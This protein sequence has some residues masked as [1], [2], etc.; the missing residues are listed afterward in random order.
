MQALYQWQLTGQ[1]TRE[2]YQQFVEDQEVERADLEYFK[3]LLDEIAQQHAS[4]DQALAP[5]TERG[6]DVVD[7]VE[8]AVLRI[9]AYELM[10]RLD[11]PYR[12]VVN[13]AIELSKK[14]GAEGSH[15][16]VNGVLDKL[17]RETRGVE[18]SMSQKT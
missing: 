7:P 12:V 4:L 5:F 18:L 8:K 14:F 13:E 15:K 11:V 10:H 1:P 9:G 2:I 6:M 3:E 16:F 17:V